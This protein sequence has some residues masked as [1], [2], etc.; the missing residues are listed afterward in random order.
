MTSSAISSFVALADIKNPD[1][2]LLVIDIV[3]DPEVP[4]LKAVL[5]CVLI[6]NERG[7]DL[8]LPGRTGMICQSLDSL[9]DLILDLRRDDPQSLVKPLLDGFRGKADAVFHLRDSLI[10]LNKR[11]TGIPPAPARTDFLPS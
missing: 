11:L 10:C 3:K 9:Y 1:D 5:G 8:G 6:N 4:D 7:F 2:L